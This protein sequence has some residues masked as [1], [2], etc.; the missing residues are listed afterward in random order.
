MEFFMDSLND[1]LGGD[2]ERLKLLD[3]SI[4]G[5][6]L[7]DSK[8]KARLK[9]RGLPLYLTV[10]NRIDTPLGSRE[11]AGFDENGDP[12]VRFSNEDMDELRRRGLFK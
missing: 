6:I 11:I 8:R 5:E 7:Q 1:K 9:E 12:K 3:D 4:L 2:E 10:G